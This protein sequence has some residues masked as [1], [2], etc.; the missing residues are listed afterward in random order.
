M[1][2]ILSI[3]LLTVCA[4]VVTERQADAWVNSKFSIGLNW[5]LQSANNNVLWGAWKNG[6]VPGPEAFGHG[7]GPL[8]F[9]P[10]PQMPPAGAFPWFG[11][12]PQGYPQATPAGF[13][14]E[15]APPPLAAQGQQT[16]FPMQYGYYNPY[17][18]VSYQPSGYYYPN[19]AQQNYYQPY[20]NQ[21]PYY[22]YQG[23]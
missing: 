20:M 2:K 11:H 17:Q 19:Y 21:A 12:N 23:R 7:G 14:T 1:K 18:T 5:H 9:G 6:Q 3:G 22:W 4:L 8:Q 16:Y 10:G 13:P 15:T